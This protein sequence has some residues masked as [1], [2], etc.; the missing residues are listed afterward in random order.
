MHDKTAAFVATE[1]EDVQWSMR[2]SEKTIC[3]GDEADVEKVPD[4]KIHCARR[5][6]TRGRRRQSRAVASTIQPSS[7]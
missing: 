4:Q 5:E 6:W 2:T 3:D 7:A 1:R